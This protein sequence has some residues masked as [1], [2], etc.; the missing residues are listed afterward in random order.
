MDVIAGMV[1]TVKL[2]LEFAVAVPTVTLIVPVLAPAGTVTVKLFAVA[3]VTVAVVPLN[4]TVLELTV[5]LKFCPW[6][7][8]V[9]PTLPCV[10]LKLRID[11]ALVEEVDRVIDWRFPTAS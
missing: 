9:C 4:F 6:M 10:G 2:L 7:T 3:A 1:S 11:S 8:T 5:V